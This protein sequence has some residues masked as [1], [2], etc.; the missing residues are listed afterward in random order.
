M[1]ALN[2][3][4]KL[5]FLKIMVICIMF[6]VM[7][8][9]LLYYNQLKAHIK[10]DRE[11][12]NTGKWTTNDEQKM[13]LNKDLVYI[14]YYNTTNNVNSVLLHT[15]NNYLRTNM[16]TL[17]FM[18]DELIGNLHNKSGNTRYILSERGVKLPYIFQ[19]HIWPDYNV[20]N[21]AE[22]SLM[23]YLGICDISQS[24]YFTAINTAYYYMYAAQHCFISEVSKFKC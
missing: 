8:I 22:Y 21:V 6:M 17:F 15:M 4:L 9:H 23:L 10:Q 24:A 18:K 1:E 7:S 13:D 19:R 11:M 5:P 16:T 3:S 14:S 2:G 20:L 12:T